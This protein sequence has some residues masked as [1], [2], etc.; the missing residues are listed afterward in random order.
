LL[1]RNEHWT[2]EGAG[3]GVI[4]E[5]K[6]HKSGAK[7]FDRSCRPLPCCG[8]G[9]EVELF[10]IKERCERDF[11]IHHNILKIFFTVAKDSLC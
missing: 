2:I 8:R 5:D 6:T 4:K 1:L 3:K 7:R 9:A 11:C 10:E